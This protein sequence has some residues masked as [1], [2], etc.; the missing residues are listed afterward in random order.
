MTKWHTYRWAIFGIPFFKTL[1]LCALLLCS[2]LVE[3]F[4]LVL[5]LLNIL[6]RFNPSVE[7]G[8]VS[9]CA[10]DVL[11]EGWLAA[12]ALNPKITIRLFR[13]IQLNFPFNVN[14]FFESDTTFA[15]DIVVTLREF[16]MA[17]HA[18]RHNL[19]KHAQPRTIWNFLNRN[20]AHVVSW[21]E[22]A[23]G[24]DGVIINWLKDSKKRQLDLIF[25]IVVKIDRQIVFESVDWVLSL[26]ELLR[27]F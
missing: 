22:F 8:T 10:E 1:I 6:L 23:F 4:Q 15:D 18:G 12:L 7:N 11:M 19:S 20:F 5:Q 9:W 16:L 26:F 2:P 25:N 13:Q 24:F 14:L 17:F 27:S 21:E 3:H